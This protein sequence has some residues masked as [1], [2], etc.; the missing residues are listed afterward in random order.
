M[1]TL[2]WLLYLAGIAG[3]LST[4]FGLSSFFMI[5][6]GG[7]FCLAVAGHT[8]KTPPKK[9]LA[10]PII[11]FIFAIIAC[12]IPNEK[13]IMYIAASEYGEK[14]VNSKEV[15]DLAN[16]A[17]ELLKTWIKK[18]TERLTKEIK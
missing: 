11:G 6:I 5:I 17:S 4:F 9:L 1:N 10:I 2:S 14:V 18:E 13:T 15:R 12:F 3:N 8:E 7:F 16:P